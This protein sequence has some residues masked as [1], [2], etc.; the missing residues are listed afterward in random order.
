MKYRKITNNFKEEQKKFLYK[1]NHYDKFKQEQ[2]EK[3]AVNGI[4]PFRPF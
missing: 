2:L 1:H 4:H 3:M